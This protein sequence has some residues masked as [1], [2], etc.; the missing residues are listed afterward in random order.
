MCVLIDE[1]HLT[2]RFAIQQNK[3]VTALKGL[4]LRW[5]QTKL[6]HNNLSDKH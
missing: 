1:I 5:K 4:F 3:T 2:S 6:S